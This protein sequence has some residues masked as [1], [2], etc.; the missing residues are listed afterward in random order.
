M[1]ELPVGQDSIVAGEAIAC[2]AWV[3]RAPHSGNAYRFRG[4]DNGKL[5]IGKA[6]QSFREGDEIMRDELYWPGHEPASASFAE[7]GDEGGGGG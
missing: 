7:A 1:G 2:D 4:F 5:V 6:R 3:V